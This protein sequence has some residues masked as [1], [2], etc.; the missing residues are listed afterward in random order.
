MDTTY[1]N[2]YVVANQPVSVRTAFIRATYT[3]LAGAIAAFGIL[4][5]LLLSIPGIE[6]TVFHILGNN[7]F[8]W[9]L[10]LGAFMGISYLANKWALQ[11]ASKSTQY[12]GLSLYVLAEAIITLPLL[13]VAKIVAGGSFSLIYQAAGISLGIFAVLTF[14]AL[15]SRTDF[16]FLGGI[17]KVVGIV[18]MI[19]IVV[20]IIFPSWIGLGLWFS[21]AMIIFASGTILYNTG[22]VLHQYPP[23]H[24]V[25]AALG[26]FASLALLFW[27]V[28]RLLIALQQRD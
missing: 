10:V 21:A 22:Q 25:A 26:L 23:T 6:Q 7:R 14:I 5:S 16:S 3:H 4:L 13:I 9:L 19:L 20:S 2:P 27:Y 8:M 12:M 11:G 24:H 1:S 28:L 15:T 17:L 18:A